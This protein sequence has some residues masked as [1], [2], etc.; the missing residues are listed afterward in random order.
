MLLKYIL[1][2]PCMSQSWCR[3]RLPVLFITQV[4]CQLS[5]NSQ[6]PIYVH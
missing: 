3:L 1:Q 4:A 2:I 6:Q 5:H